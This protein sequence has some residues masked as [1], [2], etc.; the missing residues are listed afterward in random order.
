M[1]R[2]HNEFSENKGEQK[3]D[4]KN[5]I[6]LYQNYLDIDIENGDEDKI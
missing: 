4:S 6:E 2:S 3:S 1:K 5:R